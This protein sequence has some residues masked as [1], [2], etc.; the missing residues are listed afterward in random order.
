MPT[1]PLEYRKVL[2]GGVY[3]LE[4]PTEKK[5][6]TKIVCFDHVSHS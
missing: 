2:H 5:H 1:L 3:Q 4:A 6:I